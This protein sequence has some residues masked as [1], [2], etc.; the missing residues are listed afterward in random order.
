MYGQNLQENGG[1]YKHPAVN[2]QFD[3]DFITH[4]S[5]MA[6][7]IRFS[8]ASIDTHVRLLQQ[9]SPGQTVHVSCPRQDT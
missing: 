3:P 7:S 1:A 8:S 5:V 9:K 4:F 2:S 6:G